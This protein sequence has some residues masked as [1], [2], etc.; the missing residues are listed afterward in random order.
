MNIFAALCAKGH[1]DTVETV[2]SS[3]SG[4]APRTYNRLKMIERDGYAIM[5]MM[6][7]VME[8]VRAQNSR[9]A[10][11]EHYTRSGLAL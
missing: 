7:G 5:A 4:F 10:M 8:A 11:G 9:A 6:R 1:I 3:K 2:K